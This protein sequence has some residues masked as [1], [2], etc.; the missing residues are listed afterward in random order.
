MLAGIG[1]TR[2]DYVILF[3][4][5]ESVVLARANIEWLNKLGNNTNLIK[6][7]FGIVHRTSTE[8]QPRERKCPGC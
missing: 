6:P 3:K 2:T 7:R 4:D 8:L 1:T 5:P